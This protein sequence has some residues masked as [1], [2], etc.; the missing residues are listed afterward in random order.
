MPHIGRRNAFEKLS[1]AAYLERDV[2]EGE[3]PIVLRWPDEPRAS[4]FAH[5]RF[6][7]AQ[8]QI[9]A[10]GDVAGGS[11]DSLHLGYPVQLPAGPFRATLMPNPNEVYL[12][13]MRIAR[14]LP[15]WSLG[16][17]RY[18]AQ[19]VGTLGERRDQALLAAA[20]DPDLLFAQVAHMAWGAWADVS[21][22]VLLDT[23]ERIKRR[24]EGSN[25]SLLGLLGMLYRWNDHPQFPSAIRRPLTEAILGYRY[26]LDDPGF[27]G[28][29]F[30]TD[31]NAILFHACEL[32]AGR[33]F[34]A[35]LF[36]DGQSGAWHQARGERLAQAWLTRY[37]AHGSAEW[38]SADSMARYV[39][40]LT[41]LCDMADADPII[42]MAVVA[43]DKLFFGL[44]VNSLNGVLGIASTGSSTS[45]VKSAL[46][47]PTAPIS[48]LMWSTGIYNQHLAGVVSLACSAT[49][50]MPTLFET[51][52]LEPP[53]AMWSREQD[54]P[55]DA[56]EAN[57][58]T[59]KTPDFILSSVQD[60]RPGQAGAQEQVWRAT[61]S[62]EAVVF[63]TYPGS[64][65]ES[66]TRYP[67]YWSGNVRLPRVAQ[68]QDT[69]IA[70]H[71]LDDAEPLR[72]T[73]AYFPT[74]T[75][76]EWAVR[77]G[78][79]FARRGNGYLALTNSAGFTLVTQ[80]RYA[81][82]ELRAEG[83]VQTWLV[84]MGRAARD[85]DFATFQAKI[86]AM[87]VHFSA[88]IVEAATLQGE[89]ILFSWEGPLLVNGTP[90]PLSG[91]KHMDNLY[92]STDLPCRQMEIHWQE[93][94]LRLDFTP[95]A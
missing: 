94:G 19:P 43:L 40:A 53:E 80:G 81:R 87:P 93:Q 3:T 60:Y 58:V 70:I 73:H 84:Q 31:S 47:Q 6:Q 62:A 9:Y 1:A 92:T 85:G 42:E 32:L 72:F 76:D 12:E 69:L 41:H 48:R 29:D 14:D 68:W 17:Q 5:V 2:Y 71:H 83:A 67:G 25:L 77:D 30:T 22:N 51:I 15:L 65:S 20:Y 11:G 21:V 88:G 54:A 33:R 35:H 90:Q 46:L 52:A 50:Q 24:D 38:G 55:P 63:A 44:A 61:L 23:I 27:D 8:N 56:P 66:D 74:A 36:D 82:R 34:A 86:L 89:R 4:C 37:S 7:T 49:Y 75:F 91:F 78:W 95:P 18:N 39:A 28:M 16:R 79:A 45:Y 59:Y 26:W 10:E 13:H 64:S 57:L